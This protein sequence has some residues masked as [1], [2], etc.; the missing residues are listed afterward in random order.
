MNKVVHATP[1][2]NFNRNDGGKFDFREELSQQDLEYLYEQ[3]GI[4]DMITKIEI[5]DN[6]KGAEEKKKPGKQ[7]QND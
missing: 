2:P 1:P 5:P 3:V 6:P 4:V 7:K